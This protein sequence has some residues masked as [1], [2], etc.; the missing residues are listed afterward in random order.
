MRPRSL[1]L[2]ILALTLAGVAILLRPAGWSEPS[3]AA[4]T[5]NTGPASAADDDKAPDT[6]PGEAPAPAGGEQPPA[7][8]PATRTPAPAASAPGASPPAPRRVADILAAAGDLSDPAAR[9][10]AVA[11]MRALQQERRAAAEARALQLGLPLRLVGPRGRVRELHD[12]DDDGRP[13]YRTTFNLNAA[14]TSGASLLQAETPPLT[15]SSVIV[16]VWDAGR[17]RTTHQELSGRVTVKDASLSTPDDHATHVAGTIAASGV[18]ANAKGMAPAASI[19]SYDWDDDYAEMTAAGATAAGQTTKLYLSNHSYGIVSGWDYTGSSNP[20][21]EWNGTG[22]D[23]TASDPSFGQYSADARD[24]DAVAVSTPYLLAFAAAG[25]D[26]TDNPDNGDLVRLTPNGAS[27][28]Y[29]SATHPGGD[30]IYRGGYDNISSI[31]IAKNVLTVGATTDAVSGGL[32]HVASAAVVDFSSWGP[33]DDGRIKPDLVANGDD[34]YSSVGTANTAYDTYGGTSMATP[35]AAGSAALL[36]QLYGQLFPGGALRAST[37]KALLL[38]TADDLGTAGPDYKNGW[39]LINVKA[40]ADLLRD[41][42][43]HPPKLRVNEGQLNSTTT[44]A[45]YEFTWDGTSPLR[46]TLAWTDPAG[47]ATTSGDSRTVRLVNNLDL[48]IIGPGGSTHLP[49]VMPFVGTWTPAAMALAATTGVNHTDNVEQVYVAAPP[50]AGVYQAVVTFQG[51]LTNNAQDFGLIISGSYS[52]PVAPSITTQPA[53]QSA[54]AGA[55]VTFTVAASGSAPFTYQ[56]RKGGEPITGNASAATATLTLTNVQ[57]ADAGSYDVIVTNDAGSATSTA[58]TLT[59]NVVTTSAITWNFTAGAAPSSALP[60]GL[61][62]GTVAQGNNVGTTTTLID[63]T[64]ASTGYTGASGGNNA[65]FGARTGALNTAAGGSTYLTFTLTPD[66]GKRLVVTAVSFGA[67]RSSTGP[68][69]W[70]LYSSVDNYATALATGSLPNASTWVLFT[71]TIS[72]T[73]GAL[74]APV[75]FRLYGYNGTGSYIGGAANWR[76]DDLA[77]TVAVQTAP[78][79]TVPPAAQTVA[80]GANATF[81]V[82]ATG[83][84]PFTYQWRKGGQTIAG[85]TTASYTIAGVQ[86]ADAGSYD[87]VVSNAAGSATS[88]AATLT[89]LSGF[90]AWRQQHFNETERADPLVSGPDARLTADGIANLLKY[91]LGF[92]PRDAVRPADL[93]TLEAAA[94][95]ITYTYTRPTNRSDLV[96]TV[97]SSP[98]LITWTTVTNSHERLVAGSETE[99]WRASVPLPVGGKVFLRLRVERPD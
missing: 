32:R 2:F 22:T 59:V 25:N 39:G 38:H 34:L 29:N 19:H 37:L 77:L 14:R 69:A 66:A 76:I 73:N 17:V 27:V 7:D 8:A 92:A 26:G 91:A 3:P 15:G 42:A 64:A 85:A 55:N 9:E 98:D 62:G 81:T 47:P 68:Q 89:V 18:V 13:I 5:A 75:T 41:H 86:S 70:A 56:W 90:A 65:G 79:I 31:A 48:K 57:T 11:A 84:E 40:A 45:T 99:T 20:M 33:T 71:P 43:V 49:Y 93:G 60:T 50:G 16:G 97:E 63:S 58:A 54:T 6:A 24:I 10:R 72:T 61:S 88:S 95:Q 12:F 67:R 4:P 87:V 30:G 51:S 36:V 74:G 23:A 94:G 21:W 78:T 83:T 28:A 53:A 46:A 35:S 82:T 44:S 80:A 1:A 52:P 96:Y